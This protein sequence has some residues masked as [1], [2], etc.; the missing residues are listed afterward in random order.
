[1]VT[2]RSSAALRQ[3]APLAD[4]TAAAA[5]SRSRGL[6]DRMTPEQRKIAFSYKDDITSGDPDYC[7]SALDHPG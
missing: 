6:L 5:P 4:A 3:E 1:M 7:G 2:T